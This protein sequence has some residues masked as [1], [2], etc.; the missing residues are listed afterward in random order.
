MGIAVWRCYFVKGSVENSGI[1]VAVVMFI[2]I[3]IIKATIL[4]IITMLER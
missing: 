1:I 2:V 4:L 3:A